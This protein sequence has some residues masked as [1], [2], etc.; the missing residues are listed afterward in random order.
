M[1][2]TRKDK[3]KR[4]PHPPHCLHCRMVEDYR[5]ERERQEIAWGNGGWRDETAWSR[6][7]TFKQWLMA[8]RYE[9][10]IAA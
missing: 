7:I 6:I 8:Y 1:R 4:K 2:K 9:S 3:G 5:A 10:E